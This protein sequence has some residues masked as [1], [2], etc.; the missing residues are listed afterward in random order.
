MF[1]DGTYWN[2]DGSRSCGTFRAPAQNDA[3]RTHSDPNAPPQV[4]HVV[5]PIT[6]LQMAEISQ[7]TR[8]GAIPTTISSVPAASEIRFGDTAVGYTPAV[9]LLQPGEKYSVTPFE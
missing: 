9:F 3:A 6:K 2:D 5:Q 8:S 4:A 1:A 7:L